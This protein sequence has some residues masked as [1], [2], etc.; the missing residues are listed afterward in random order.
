[1]LRDVYSGRLK[2][3]GKEHERTLIAARNWRTPCGDIS[4]E[5]AKSLLRETVPVTQR[6][7]ERIMISRSGCGRVTRARSTM[8]RAPHSTILRRDDARGRQRIARRVGGAHPS[9]WIWSPASRA[10]ALRAREAQ[11]GRG[12]RK[13]RRR[14]RRPPLRA[15][16][17]AA[18]NRR[19]RRARPRAV[20]RKRDGVA[21]AAM[22]RSAAA[23]RARATW[24]RLIH[25]QT[26]GRIA[27]VS[28]RRGVREVRR[29]AHAHGP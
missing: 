6:A 16:A 28:R 3:Y 11:P 21:G 15:R 13:H 24:T 2:L 14:R 17:A 10:S 23:P 29:R 18:A 20:Q 4:A 22:A 9:W 7:L 27:L 8:T 19:R 1:M 12:N 26:A 5:E 25:F